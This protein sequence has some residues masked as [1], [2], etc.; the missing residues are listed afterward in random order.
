MA[1]VL[2]PLPSPYGAADQLSQELASWLPRLGSANS[3]Y[4][5]G[6]NTIV[7]RTRDL[8]RNSGWAS[9]AVTR[10]LDNIIGS[11]FR[12]S[13]KPDYQ[14]LGQTDDW[15]H[16]FA[17]EIEAGWRQ[18]A[19][20]PDN[21]ADATR[22]NSVNGLF[23]IAFRTRFVDGD[24]FAA[25]LW[26]DSK[27]GG[28]YATT[29][30]LID[31]DRVCNPYGA[32]DSPTLRS[33]IEIDEYGAPV[34]YNVRLAHPA[35]WPMASKAFRW[36]RVARETPW[37]RRQMLHTFE[38]ERP[39]QI[40]GVSPL[41][42]ILERL[43]M[44]DKYDKVE[45]QAAVLNA[46]FAAF[47][48]SPFDHEMLDAALSSES[49]CLGQYQEMRSEYHKKRGITLNG[50]AIPK[51]FPGE[52]F[53]M[54]AAARPAAQFGSF[55][56]AC[57]RNIA[58]GVGLSYEQLSQDWSKTNYSSARAALLEVWRG[59]GRTRARFAEQFATPVFALWLEEAINRGDINLPKGAPDFY[60]AKAA[61]CRLKWIGPARGW[62]DP[63]KEAQAAQMR[64]DIGISTLEDECSEQ[65][66]DWEEVLHQRK[67]ELD[68]MDKLGLPRPAWADQMVLTAAGLPRPSDNSSGGDNGTDSSSSDGNSNDGSKK[69]G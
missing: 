9:G 43:K 48:E 19:E 44:L 62:V 64:M 2:A 7:A 17:G 65:G 49:H 45:L 50:V 1:S 68:M 8:V 5:W 66:K 35:D 34:A 39:D 4:L 11:G 32:A 26:L 58:A 67:R 38:M 63:T 3:D 37:G 51:L 21:W 12:L 42:P 53:G 20:D 36:E 41:A 54:Q 22:H 69:N 6:R 28:K 25:A 15:A 46:I 30:Q 29:I 61:Y 27:P 31:P 56:E 33:G 60:E 52:R 16:E 47:I 55:E 13:S 23:G 40:R 14:A 10:H 57:L 18:F 24:A 59:F